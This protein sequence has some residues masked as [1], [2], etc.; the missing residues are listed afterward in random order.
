M[1]SRYKK[2]PR[3]GTM[4]CVPWLLL[5]LFMEQA[6][7]TDVGIVATLLALHCGAETELRAAWPVSGAHVGLYFFRVAGQEGLSTGYDSQV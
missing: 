2:P 1:R 4:A 5:A 6:V 7:G 3:S